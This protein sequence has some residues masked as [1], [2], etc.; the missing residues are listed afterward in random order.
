MGTT[1]SPS[2]DIFKLD[3]RPLANLALSYISFNELNAKGANCQLKR[4]QKK[5][6]TPCCSRIR[7]WVT[8]LPLPLPSLI[9][10]PQAWPL[11]LWGDG[12]KISEQ[13]TS[14]ML[15]CFFSFTAS[16]IRHRSFSDQSSKR[17]LQWESDPPERHPQWLGLRCWCHP[18]HIHGLQIQEEKTQWAHTVYRVEKLALKHHVI[19]SSSIYVSQRAPLRWSGWPV[20][21]HLKGH[22]FWAVRQSISVVR[23]KSVHRTWLYLFKT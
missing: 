3:I 19:W 7:S 2:L 13:G 23:W 21:A 17:S 4:L 8:S 10:V 20:D 15:L 12:D 16:D 11:F 6:K 18:L 1:L 5:S 14:L 22:A 9:S